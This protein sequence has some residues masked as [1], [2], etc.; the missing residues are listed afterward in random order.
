MSS[1]LSEFPIYYFFLSS[2]EMRGEGVAIVLPPRRYSYMYIKRTGVLVGNFEKN[3]EVTRGR[4]EMFSPLS[5]TNS[6]NR[7]FQIISCHI[8]SG[9]CPKK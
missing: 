2:V 9:Q 7:T 6:Q 4:L 1:N 3:K 5:E 8:F